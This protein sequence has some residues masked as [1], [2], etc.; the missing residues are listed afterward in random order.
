MRVEHHDTRWCSEPL[1]LAQRFHQ[2]DLMA[3][4]HA[5]EIA[6]RERGSSLL[7]RNLLKSFD[8]LHR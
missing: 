3:A 4:V 6:D 2:Q 8:H 7:G 5:V 1:R